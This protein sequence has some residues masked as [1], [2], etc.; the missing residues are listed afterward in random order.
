M[1]PRADRNW[2]IVSM[3]YRDPRPVSERH[4]AGWTSRCEKYVVYA[5]LKSEAERIVGAWLAN[6]PE[7]GRHLNSIDYYPRNYVNQARELSA[8]GRVIA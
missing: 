6:D 7:R 8:A 1:T 4:P 2:T 5:P 3:H